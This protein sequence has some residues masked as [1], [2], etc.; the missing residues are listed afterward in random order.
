METHKNKE[1][2]NL[3]YIWKSYQVLVDLIFNLEYLIPS[4]DHIQKAHYRKQENNQMACTLTE[5]IFSF[6][7]LTWASALS[8]SNFSIFS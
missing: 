3:Q 6:L 2:G 8:S 7:N 5:K 4:P 1:V